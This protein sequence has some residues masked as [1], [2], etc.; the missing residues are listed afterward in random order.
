MLAKVD[1]SPA[2]WTRST[3]EPLTALGACVPRSLTAAEERTD[4]TKHARVSRPPPAISASP[5]V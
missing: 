4:A 1:R 3:V 2:G 5:N